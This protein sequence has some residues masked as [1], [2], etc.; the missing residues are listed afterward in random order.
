MIKYVLLDLDDTI[1]DFKMS[2]RTALTKALTDLGVSVNEDIVKK[3][4]EYN[5][6][7]WKR[8]ELGEITRDEVKINRYKLLFDDMGID[9]SPETATKKYENYLAQGHFF[10]DGAKELLECIC[11]DYELYLVS[12]GSKRVQSGRLKSADITHLFKDIFVSEDIGVEKPNADFFNHVFS[13]IENFDKTQT[14]IIGDSLSSDI[15]GGRNAAIKTVW[16]NPN[17]IKNDSGIIPDYEIDSLSKLPD[18][19]KKI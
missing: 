1:L 3:Y 17:H 13:R 11:N 16:F 7:Q 18:L 15:R 14:V 2:E 6:S 12:N 5:I 8:L 19:L 10:I 4:S 9:L